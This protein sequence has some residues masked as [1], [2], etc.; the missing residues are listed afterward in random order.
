[1]FNRRKK[2]QQ[3]VTHIIFKPAV[4]TFIGFTILFGIS[5]ALIKNI[6]KQYQINSEIAGLQKEIKDFE[7]KNIELKD[8]FKYLESD[9]FASEQARMNLNYKKDGEEVVVIKTTDSEKAGNKK[10]DNT[11]SVQGLGDDNETNNVTNATLW[12]RYFFY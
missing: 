10:V 1:M 2:Q 6:K 12:W 8:K 11:F 9:Q 4:L 5:Y 3:Q 7:T